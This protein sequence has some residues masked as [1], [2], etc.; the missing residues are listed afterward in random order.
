M[1]GVFFCF[2]LFFFSSCL[3]S[4]CNPWGYDRPWASSHYMI[5]PGSMP[6]KY[7]WSFPSLLQSQ[8]SLRLQNHLL[9]IHST[10]KAF[11][12]HDLAFFCFLRLPLTPT[13][14]LRM[15]LASPPPTQSRYFVLILDWV[16]YR[17]SK[18][19]R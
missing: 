2:F 13:H 10:Q 16:F 3:T 11:K 17:S 9:L 4:M 5:L 6:Q 1:K 14:V 19:K 12:L 18:Y 8:L 7:T 15:L